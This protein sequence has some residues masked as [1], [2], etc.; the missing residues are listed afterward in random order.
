MF[1]LSKI[2]VKVIAENENLKSYKKK[3]YNYLEV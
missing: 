3:R 2:R 1:G